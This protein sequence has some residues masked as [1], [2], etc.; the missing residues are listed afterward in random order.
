M[1]VQTIRLS[2]ISKTRGKEGGGETRIHAQSCVAFRA[3]LRSLQKRGM[4]AAGGDRSE[5][6][7]GMSG[8]G[9]IQGNKWWAYGGAR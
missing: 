4:K 8:T 5:A 1:R 6:G 9:R 7:E 2:L 3:T